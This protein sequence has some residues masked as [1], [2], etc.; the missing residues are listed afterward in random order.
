MVVSR[1]G[2]SILLVGAA[3][4]HAATLPAFP[5]YCAKDMDETSIP[6]LNDSVAQSFGGEVSLADVELLQV[7][8]PWSI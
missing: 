2:P 5:R 6:P 3:S 8:V 7:G 1:I 4:T